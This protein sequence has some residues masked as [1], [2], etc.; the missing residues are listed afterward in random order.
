MKKKNIVIKS[1]VSSAKEAKELLGDLEA[2]SGKYEVIIDLKIC[3]S[4]Q[5]HS[6]QELFPDLEKK[7][8]EVTT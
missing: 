5:K 8:K 1:V 6:E 2:L 4:M 3:P 7:K